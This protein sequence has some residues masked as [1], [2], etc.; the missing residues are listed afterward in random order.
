MRDLRV[1]LLEY[2]QVLVS[3]RSRSPEDGQ[4][5]DLI[6]RLKAWEAAQRASGYDVRLHLEDA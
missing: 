1:E 6:L 4:S 3:P 5:I 2:D